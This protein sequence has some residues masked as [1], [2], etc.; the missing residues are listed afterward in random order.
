MILG[1][2]VFLYKRGTPAG[3]PRCIHGVLIAIK[4]SLLWSPRES[5]A[6]VPDRRWVG[7]A[8]SEGVHRGEPAA[9]TL[10]PLK[11]DE[12]WSNMMVKYGDPRGVG[13][14]YERGTS[15]PPPWGQA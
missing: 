12:F 8:G 5:F 13:V 1:E 3:L 2:W 15:V 10:W 11:G 9:L 7:Q 4:D 6:G 14:S